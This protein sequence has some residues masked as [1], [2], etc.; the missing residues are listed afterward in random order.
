MS[1]VRQRECFYHHR[2][3]CGMAAAGA[4]AADRQA[5]DHRVLGGHYAFG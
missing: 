5:A 3:R 2:R 4:R 1:D